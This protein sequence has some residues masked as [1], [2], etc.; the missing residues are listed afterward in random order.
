[1]S[2]DEREVAVMPRV[3]TLGE[4]LIDFVPV[5]SGLDLA[6]VPGFTKAPGG[7]PAN[8]AVG[9][10]RL[11]IKSGFIGKLA[12]DAFGRYLHGVLAGNGV[13]GRGI[14]FTAEGRTGLAFISLTASGQRDFLFYRERGADTLLE[15]GDIDRVDL[16][17]AEVLHHGSVSLTGQPSR[18]ATEKAVQ[19][20][21]R[22]G[23]KISFDPNL[24]LSLWPSGA[25]ARDV[26]C[27]MMSAV[28][29]LKLNEEELSFLSGRGDVEEGARW[30]LERQAGLVVVTLGAGG[31]LFM[32][33][34]SQGR[35]PG[36]PVRALDTTGAGDAFMAG[37]LAALLEGAH[38][39]WASLDGDAL[40]QACRFAN[41]AAAI[42]TT[43]MG[44]I[45]SLAFKEEVL[46]F[47]REAT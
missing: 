2:P 28:D 37:L 23:L 33:R 36:W 18:G 42:S 30:A 44:A 24:R 14:S 25:H 10:C 45:G 38:A 26:V 35:V 15:E 6:D 31:C 47:L 17:G 5:E 19:S 43:R 20:G 22:H 34:V 16:T 3:M 11:G 8:V 21:R 4:A 40:G 13:D 1:M 29:L 12:D 27:G 39:G 41:A 32:N 7:A 46:S 9:L